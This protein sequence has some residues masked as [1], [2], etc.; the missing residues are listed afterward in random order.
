MSSR[1]IIA[2]LLL[3][4]ALGLGQLKP[5]HDITYSEA[6]P[7]LND[8]SDDPPA[9][10]RGL[11]P[12]QVQAKWPAYVSEQDRSTRER[13]LQG[14]EDSLVNL[15]LYG[16]SFTKEPRLTA[17]FLKQNGMSINP[18]QRS[19]V[20]DILSRRANDVIA[21]MASPNA[22]E[23]L[24]YMRGLMQKR[25][26]NVDTPAAREKLHAYLLAAVSRVYSEFSQFEEKLQQ[27]REAGDTG[28]EFAIRSTLFQQRGISLDTS[29]MPDYAL[30][31]ALKEI[32]R[33]HLF[34]R[35]GIHRVAV[36]GPGLDFTDKAE[37]FDF[38][39]QQTTQPFLLLDSLIRIGLSNPDQVELTTLDISPRVN[40]HV[41]AMRRNA[42]QGKPYDIQMPLRGDKNWTAG[43]R[44]FWQNAGSKIA[45]ATKAVTVPPSEGKVEIRAIRVPTATVLR[46]HPRDENVVWQ[47]LP[48]NEDEKY[49]L[50]VATNIL[51]YYDEFHQA[52]ALANIQSM[53]KPGGLLLTNDGLPDVQTLS[54]HQ[55][56][57]SST[58]YSDEKE[59]GDHII[60]YQYKP[61]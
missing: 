14:D 5:A 24:R 26:Q 44:E 10:L 40:E 34:A 4:A 50:I 48:L 11:T 7:V 53:L 38:Y 46:I 28:V 55:I 35:D 36:I 57:G 22:G 29:I 30:E 3:S 58:A 60:W 13:L 12:A 1:R 19:V 61:R 23:R 42:S 2:F 56:G 15:L 25:G 47:R 27:A 31:E 59:D 49:D 17:E 16:T 18:A 39:P 52:L 33:V 43:A 21:A 37:G 8:F 51:V 45:A 6:K 41:A 9:D 54:I 32:L 20:S